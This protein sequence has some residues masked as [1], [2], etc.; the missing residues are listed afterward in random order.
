MY[1]YIFKFS[2]SWFHAFSN[3]CSHRA[4]T[5]NKTLIATK[6]RRTNVKRKRKDDGGASHRAT[7]ERFLYIV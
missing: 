1:I 4:G 2:H 3:V 6:Q 5:V 7:R